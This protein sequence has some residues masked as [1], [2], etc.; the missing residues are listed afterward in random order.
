MFSQQNYVID[1]EHKMTQVLLN[2]KDVENST[3]AAFWMQ[4]CVNETREMKAVE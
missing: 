2:T 4:K 1:D 3:N